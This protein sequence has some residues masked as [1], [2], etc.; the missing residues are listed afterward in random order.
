[1][2]WDRPRHDPTYGAGATW[3][4]G[5]G[6]YSDRPHGDRDYREREHRG[7]RRGADVY[8]PSY[9]AD[10]RRDDRRDDRRRGDSS[11]DRRP[12]HR[13]RLEPRLDYDERARGG[14]RSSGRRTRSRSRS[15]VRDRAR[16]RERDSPDRS[17]VYRR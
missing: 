6:S 10:G 11:Y 8:V 1:M 12:L 3:G 7:D 4:D 9:G 15:P 14:G 5:G 16:T 13:D 2:R 17:N